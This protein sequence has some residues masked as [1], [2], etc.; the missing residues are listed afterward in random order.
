MSTPK[1]ILLTA[2]LVLAAVLLRAVADVLLLVFA[3]ILLAIPLRWIARTLAV[4]AGLRTGW[5][6]AATIVVLGGGLAAL[7]W[8]TAP[9]IAEQV[10]RP[11]GHHSGQLD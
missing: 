6:L 8:L 11:R 7:A 10:T 2:A 4:R 5:V 1:A 3:G 9:G